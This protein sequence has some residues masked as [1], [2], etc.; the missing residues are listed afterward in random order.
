MSEGTGTGVELDGA[1]SDA[2]RV[3]DFD[4]T[5]AA[6][7]ELRGIWKSFGSNTV[8]RGVDLKVRPGEIV[9][10]LGGSGSGKSVCLKHVIGLLR[11]DSGQVFVGG[12]DVTAYSERAWVEVRKQFGYVFQGAALFDS[13]SVAENIAY[14]LREHLKWREAEIA[15]RVAECLAAVALPGTEELM[16]AELSGGMRKR[17]GVARAIALEPSVILYDEPTTGLD[18]ANSRRIGQLILALRRRLGATAVVVTH[19]LEICFTV[20]DRIVLL[21]G[22]NFVVEGTP[23]EIRASSHPDVLEFLEGGR[24]PMDAES[25]PRVRPGSSQSSGGGIGQ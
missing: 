6:A 24:E 12:D 19:D 10:I 14:P 16:P 8:L 7:I 11:P 13:L 17:I 9:T 4:Q 23:D 22:G 20:S 15:A 5:A 25:G 21:K 2:P 18:P 3:A 1:R